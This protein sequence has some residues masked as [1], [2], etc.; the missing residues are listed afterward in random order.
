LTEEA[1][2]AD[3]QVVAQQQPA[4][5]VD[6][7]SAAEDMVMSDELKALLDRVRGYRMTP[8]EIR[9]QAISFAFGNGHIEDSRVT[10]EGIARAVDALYGERKAH[11]AK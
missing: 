3:N 10:R 8:E 9:E 2:L 1:A 6:D 7:A 11:A 5:A 4:V